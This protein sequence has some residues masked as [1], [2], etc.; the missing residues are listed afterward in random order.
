MNQK[1]LALQKARA[2]AVAK[3]ERTFAAAEAENRPPTAE[4]HA[5]FVAARG[6]LESVKAQIEAAEVMAAERAELASIPAT[7]VA[8]LGVEASAS[9]RVTVGQDNRERAPWGPTPQA[10]FG[11]FMQAVHRAEPRVAGIVDPRLRPLT[12]APAGSNEGQGS[13]GGFLLAPQAVGL[14]DK[15]AFES[16]QLAQR[17]FAIEVGDGFNG[18][19]VDIIDETS[20]VT[21]SR[22]G[23]VQVYHA[24]EGAT[25]ASSMPKVS[26][27][28]MRLEKIMGL[29]YV[30]DEQLADS[31]LLASIGPRA[32]GEE[33]AFQVDE[34]IF[35][36][37]GAGMALGVLRSGA[38]IQV[39][40]ET[41]QADA[42]IEAANLRKMR[43]R[44]PAGDRLNTIITMHADAEAELLAVHEKIGIAGELVYIPAGRYSDEPFGRLWGMPVI[45]TEHNKKLGDLGDVVAMNLQRYY[46]IRKGGVG[47]A[48]SVHVRFIYDE[49][50]FRFTARVN[51]CPM[52]RSAI[53]PAQGTNTVSPFV[54]L[55]ERK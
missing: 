45:V 43:A 33:L 29:W 10:A 40:K 12:A 48:S 35:D 7:A 14:V 11:A 46:L 32:F 15:I 22:W 38:L 3:M 44:I 16:S 52:L 6:E 53:T 47:V 50:A 27:V 1:I 42:T 34:D 17:C 2:A 21:G 54:A 55:A 23:G 39:P 24:A 25:V 31:S 26:K 9:P 51:G 18:A 28:A 5:A 13:E 37:S 8:E 36:G 20:R 41:G 30:S 49:T 4:E 19:E